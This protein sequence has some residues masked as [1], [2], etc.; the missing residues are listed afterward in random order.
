MRALAT[1]SAAIA[2]VLSLSTPAFSQPAVAGIVRD[3]SGAILPGV[4]V[5]ASSPVLIEKS[6]TVVTDGTGQYR[7]VDL[8]PGTY[9]V[10]F[11][12]SGFSTIKREAVE[13]TGAGV[14]TINADMRV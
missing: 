8:K 1:L 5:E 14:T 4:S 3:S 2:A 9:T 12:L 13:L 10:T 6:R 11:A 7:I